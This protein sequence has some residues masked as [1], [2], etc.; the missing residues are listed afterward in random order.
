MQWACVDFPDP[1][2]P[3]IN[4]F[5]PGYTRK[6]ISVNVGSTCERYLNVYFQNF[7]PDSAS[8]RC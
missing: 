1:D 7:I 3:T 8:G 6:L 4:T 2:G 5:S